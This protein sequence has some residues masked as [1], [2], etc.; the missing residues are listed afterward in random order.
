MSPNPAEPDLPN[1]G[2]QP[3]E[4][5]PQTAPP[6]FSLQPPV[7][8]R[9]P[10]WTDSFSLAEF[11]RLIQHPLVL[12][13]LAVLIIVIIVLSLVIAVLPWHSNKNLVPDG[14]ACP[15]LWISYRGACYYFSQE[16]K[17]WTSSQ[18]FCVSFHSSLVTTEKKETEDFV[19]SYTC[20]GNYWLG[21]KKENNFWKWLNGDY[22]HVH[23]L[24]YGGSCAYLTNARHFEVRSS[25]CS[26]PHRWICSKPDAFQKPKGS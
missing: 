18:H 11:N 5:L 12:L 17:G 1:D 23:V 2:A 20:S 13:I 16:E 24:E 6:P 4:K 21:L 22:A 26:V 8:Q 9:P 10:T 15:V 25:L 14:P 19:V 3:P 7:H